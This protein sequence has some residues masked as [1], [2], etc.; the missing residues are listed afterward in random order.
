MKRLLLFFFLLS[1]VSACQQKSDAEKMAADLCDC[2]QPLTEAF[3]A[4]ERLSAEGDVEGLED[5]MANM[6]ARARTSE[7]C[8]V[9]LEEKYGDAMREQ[10][11]QI[12]EIMARECPDVVAAMQKADAGFE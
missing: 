9:R 6:E 5:A 3:Q 4:I 2:M 1:L 8:T 12:R 7:A 10:E 11:T